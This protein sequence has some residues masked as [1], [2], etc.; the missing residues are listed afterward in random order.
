MLVYIVSKQFAS[1][2]SKD[3]DVLK[4]VLYEYKCV[5]VTEYVENLEQAHI[6][7][8]LEHIKEDWLKIPS[9]KTYY[10]P[11][12]EMLTEWDI[13]LMNKVDA[14]LCK[15]EITFKK[16]NHKNKI[17]TK[18][19]S[20]C[21]ETHHER[22]LNYVGHFAG[23]SMFKNTLDVLKFWLKCDFDKTLL[24]SVHHSNKKVWK[25]FKKLN[26]VEEN[27]IFNRNIQHY[28][29]KNVKMFGFISP[30]EP[31]LAIPS[32]ELTFEFL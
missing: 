22:K 26:P 10:I 7:I 32:E 21:P 24:L 8:F 12:I 19:T 15:N 25:F 30:E 1:G 6:K 14:V 20:I 13:K 23:T 9:V 4:K 11:N 16:I 3:F 28:S 2:L 17:L 31:I 5:K 18:F 29:Y 27:E